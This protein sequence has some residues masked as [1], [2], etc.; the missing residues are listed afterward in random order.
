MK[1][2]VSVKDETKKNIEGCT[3]QDKVKKVCKFERIICTIIIIIGFFLMDLNEDIATSVIL[4]GI[5]L[6]L[7]LPKL[8]KKKLKKGIEFSQVK[9][10]KPA[11]I[12]EV[13]TEKEL[14]KESEKNIKLE[15]DFKLSDIDYE[16][17]SIELLREESE[18][19]D[20]IQSK[21]YIDSES[22]II[23]GIKENAN[24]KIIDIQETSHMLIAG[25]T[26]IGK[27]TL[28]DNIIINILYKS[29]P[30]ETKFVMFDTNNNS[31]RL[32]SGIP[33]LL[34]PVI[35]DAKKSVGALE[36]IVQE[37][38]NRNKLFLTENAEDFVKF[39]KKMES[40]NKNKLPTIVVI[41]DEISDIVN[42][43]KE[44]VEDALI[45]ITKKGKKTGI[46]LI[47][48][49]NRPSAD[50][51][52][53]SIKANIYTRISF[54]LP[55]RLDSKL[56]LDMDGAEKLKNHGD[57]L[58]K[59]IGITTPKKYHCPYISIDEIKNVVNFLTNGGS[60][61]N[62][63]VLEKIGKAN[64][65]DKELEE[66]LDDETDIFLMDAIEAVIEVGQ[67]SASF[68][69]RR[70]KLGYARAGRIIDQMEARGIISGYEGSKPR[71][72]LISK[73]EWEQLK[74]I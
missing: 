54:F 28:L 59:T 36:W 20:V 13:I 68:I 18:I 12:H 23:V 38:E 3:E 41:I 4:I 62:E 46:F 42:N 33:H 40:Y 11:D 14:F 64:S 72:V 52:S 48:S 16:F 8:T 6:I 27:T 37:I 17:P 69:Q 24:T 43:D 30:E 22:K 44:N 57:I 1:K 29:K 32:Y 51:I 56:I 45:R 61:Y 34:I 35:K 15:S 67:A 25:T 60:D 63:D 2:Y 26:G 31:L 66:Y 53:G 19:K 10:E 70:F 50:I 9:T 71:K 73:E 49:T 55:S 7:I 5:F 65:I 39:N 58:F 74:N 21:E 47:I